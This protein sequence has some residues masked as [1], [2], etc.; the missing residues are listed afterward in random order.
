MKR[1]IILRHADREGDELTPQGVGAC[2]ELAQKLP[3]FDIVVAS[4]AKRTQTTAGLL[5]GQKP[6]IEPVLM[7]SSDPAGAKSL[8][9]LAKKLLGQLPANGQ[10]LIVSHEVNILALIKLLQPTIAIVGINKLSGISLD[11]NLNLDMV[12]NDGN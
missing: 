3:H 12:N 9:D 5:T 7:L 10:A 6:A 4:P 11:E 8:L 2:K 1:V